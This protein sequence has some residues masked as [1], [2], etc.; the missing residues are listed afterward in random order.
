MNIDIIGA[1]Y[2]GIS[3]VADF[4]SGSILFA[5]IKFFLFAYSIVLLAD[6]VMMLI[7]RG[8]SSDLKKTLYGTDRPFLSRSV[9]LKRWEKIAVRLESGNP[10]QY[11]VAIL[12]ADA[13]AD[14]ILLGIGYNGSNMTERLSSIQEGQLETKSLLEDAHAIR[15][16]IV[17]EKDFVIERDETERLL[18]EYR[19]F[20]DE[21]ELF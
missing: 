19:E 9:M 11:K 5:F 12:E 8:V 3:G 4:L 20:F 17:H 13:L 1:A 18:G 10:S 2:E 7:L 16:R 15:N 21:V 6:I 14:E